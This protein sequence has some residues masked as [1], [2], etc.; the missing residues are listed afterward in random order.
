MC[1]FILSAFFGD[2]NDT[3]NLSGANFDK[4]SVEVICA[5]VVT[6]KKNV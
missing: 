6:S 2:A 3:T 4:P 1:D 5:C